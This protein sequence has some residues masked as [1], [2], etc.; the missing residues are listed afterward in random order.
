LV[1]ESGSQLPV[2]YFDERE[3]ELY[4]LLRDAAGGLVSKT[5]LSR[6]K[7]EGGYAYTGLLTLPPGVTHGRFSIE[8]VR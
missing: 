8:V 3:L 2:S 4:V 6:Q 1:A 7:I 5:K